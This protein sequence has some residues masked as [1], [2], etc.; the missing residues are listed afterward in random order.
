[1]TPPILAVAN[2][3]GGV[4]KTA[5]VLGLAG[6]ALAAGRT[7]LVVDL[8]PQGNATDVLG[9]ADPDATGS[10]AVVGDPRRGG[11]APLATAVQTCADAWTGVQVVAAGPQLAEVDVDTAPTQPTR[12][13]RA[14][15]DADLHAYDVVLLDCPPSLGRLLVAGLVAATHLL[16]VTEPTGHAL[17]GVARLEETLQET[18]TGFDQ[19]TPHLAAV[20]LTRVKRA[21]EHTHRAAELRDAYGDLVL[22]TEV[23]ERVAVTDAASRGQPLH[24][25]PGDGARTAAAA[26]AAAWTDLQ[27][28]LTTPP[29]GP[30]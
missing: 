8:D 7:V 10:Y 15:A 6:A 23:P 3:K 25:L 24:A 16:V 21:A 27:P 12:L 2:Q 22:P 9:A 30:A 13:R 11:G 17:A 26:Y 18:L 5:S 1:M 29:G 14:L 20:L 19:T 4:G 28:R